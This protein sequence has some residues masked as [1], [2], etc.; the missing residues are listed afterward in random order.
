MR[1]P[2][3]AAIDSSCFSCVTATKADIERYR[4][5]GNKFE[6]TQLRGIEEWLASS[7]MQVRRGWGQCRAGCCRRSRRRR[8]ETPAA[9]PAGRV[10]GA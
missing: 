5:S 4:D 1:L 7:E 10:K 2:D 6:S 3:L 8:D 9:S